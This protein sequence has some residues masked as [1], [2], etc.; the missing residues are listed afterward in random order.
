MLETIRIGT[1]GS[2]LALWQA[3]HVADLLREQ[4]PD[5]QVE[6]VIFTT[7]GDK[8]LDKSLPSIGGKGLF[9]EELESALLKDD[10]DAIGDS[11][12]TLRILKIGFLSRTTRHI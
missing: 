7:K 3:N 6:L 4:Y 9:T 12:W 10:I 11:K 1:R 5:T 2:Q 8:I